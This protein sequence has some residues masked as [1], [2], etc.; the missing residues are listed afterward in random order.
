MA[1]EE[2]KFRIVKDPKT[3]LWAY[4]AAGEKVGGFRTAQEARKACDR[5]LRSIKK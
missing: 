1:I 2:N 5:F 3:D 4:E